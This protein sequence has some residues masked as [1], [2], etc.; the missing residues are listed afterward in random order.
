MWCSLLLISLLC[1]IPYTSSLA[2]SDARDS[3][4]EDICIE[5][6]IEGAC[7]HRG[8]AELGDVGGGV[9]SSAFSRGQKNYRKSTFRQW[10]APNADGGFFNRKQE[11]CSNVKPKNT[12]NKS[13]SEMTFYSSGF[14]ILTNNLSWLWALTASLSANSL[15]IQRAVS[16]GPDRGSTVNLL[17]SSCQTA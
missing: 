13:H 11:E 15:K 8:I 16:G 10:N 1:G 3:S 14:C 5:G 17:V 12:E 2:A 4:S 6:T 9:K 7:Q